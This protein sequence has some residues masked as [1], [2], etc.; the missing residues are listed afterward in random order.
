MTTVKFY[1]A[2][3]AAYNAGYLH[4]AWITAT[5][6]ADDMQ[7]Q[8]NAMLAKSPVGD[9]EEWLIHDYDDE[10]RAISH[11]GETSDLGRIAEIMDAIE[12]IESDYD[13]SLLPILIGWVSDMQDDPA[14]WASVLSDAFAGIYDDAEDYAA[15]F[16]E[17]CGDLA[18]VPEHIARYIDY[19]AMARD[20]SLGGDLDFVCT[21]TGDHLQDYDSMR[22]RE[23]I[24]LRNF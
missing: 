19:K 1:A 23:C 9:A 14:L 21:S 11:L 5:S 17:D 10:L 24:V 2:D 13:A 15:Q 22:G 20:F 12:T 18:S 6:D 7:E 16:C 8:V 4:G 3:L